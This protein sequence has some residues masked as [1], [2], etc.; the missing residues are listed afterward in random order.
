MAPAPDWTGF[1]AGVARGIAEGRARAP[2][3]AGRPWAGWLWP[4]GRWPWRP[5]LAFGGALAAAALISLTLWQASYPPAAPEGAVVVRSART[6]A[7][8]GSVMVYS[9]PERDLAVIWVFGLE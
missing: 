5:R 8:G 3:G 1:W 2:L 6:D 7:P 9:P 4:G